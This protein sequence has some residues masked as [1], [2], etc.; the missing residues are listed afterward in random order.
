MPEVTDTAATSDVQ[1]SQ[2]E[3]VSDGAAPNAPENNATEQTPTASLRFG[4]KE[5]ELK[6]IPATEGAPGMDISKLLTTFGVD[7]P[8]PRVHQHRLDHVRCHLHRR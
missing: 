1:T 3:A 5:L 8:R 2:P 6:V 7:H 4:D